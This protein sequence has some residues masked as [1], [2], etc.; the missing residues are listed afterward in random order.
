MS[1]MQFTAFLQIKGFKFRWNKYQNVEHLQQLL[2]NLRKQS[3]LPVCL[4]YLLKEEFLLY[5]CQE[6]EP[7]NDN[8]Q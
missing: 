7:T 6:N 2:K 4:W 5:T 8:G 3:Q 1:T